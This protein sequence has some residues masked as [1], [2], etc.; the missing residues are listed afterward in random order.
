MRRRIMG[1]KVGIGIH[2]LM[3]LYTNKN[4]P[5]CAHR[6]Q[7]VLL[8]SVAFLWGVSGAEMK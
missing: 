5:T 2:E 4:V 6:G 3:F 8:G 7:N 1:S